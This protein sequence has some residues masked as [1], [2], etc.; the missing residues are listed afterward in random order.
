MSEINDLDSLRLQR[1]FSVKFSIFLSTSLVRRQIRSE[2]L[3][4]SRREDLK[5]YKREFNFRFE[6]QVL[7][8]KKPMG[9]LL[10]ERI[11]A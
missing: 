3:E 6:Q 5:H 8:I 9:L 10:C 4:Q 2:L 7:S 11:K 1:W